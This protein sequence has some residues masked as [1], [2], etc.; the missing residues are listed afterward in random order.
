LRR[1][2]AGLIAGALLAGAA[3]AQE[4]A[5]GAAVPDSA[6]ADS[7]AADTTAAPPPPPYRPDPAAAALASFRLERSVDVETVAFGGAD[8]PAVAPGFQTLA[9]ILRLEPSV[10][11]RELSV[12]PTVETF[13][14]NG[15]GSGR[16]DLLLGSRSLIV[17]G[18]S[19]PITN[20]IMLS[21][22]GAARL[23][24][25]GASALYGPDAASGALV[26][27][28]ALPVPPELTTRAFAEEGVDGYERAGLWLAHRAGNRGSVFLTTESRRVDGF[29]P[30]TE[31]VDRQFSARVAARVGGGV[32]MTAALRQYKG[33]ARFGGFAANTVGSVVTRRTDWELG[34]FRATGEESGV[35]FEA[36]RA[37]ER[38]ETDPAPDSLGVIHAETSEI[39]G[40][41]LRLTADLPAAAGIRSVLRVE[42]SR[43]RT[44]RE[45]ADAVEELRRGA[46]ALRSTLAVGE[47]AG[48]TGTVRLDGEE[49]RRTARQGRAEAWWTA[50]PVRLF[51]VGA[52]S[53]RRAD[54]GAEGSELETHHSVQG[55]ARLALGGLEARAAGFY[56]IIEDYRREPTL[57][58]IRAR[59]PVTDAPLG[60][61]RITGADAGLATGRFRVPGVRF[62]GE[63]LLRT[64]VTLQEA[65]SRDGRERLPGRPRRIWTGE[66]FLERP[67]FQGDLLARV[68]GRLTHWGD[69]V[70]D[71]GLPVIN[72]W[73]TDVI[74]EGEIGD[75]VFFYRFHD[76]LERAD[77][78]E[79]GVRFPGFTRTYGVSWRFRG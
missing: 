59:E 44:E 47:G 73:L 68:R 51:G 77:E 12:G 11:T 19:G 27:E 61:A 41:M 64:S 54:A 34:L 9:D 79:P 69:R 17:P 4:P 15:S 74:L 30:G 45:M 33:D 40:P 26:V 46:A 3:P 48:V 37:G 50:G 58:E 1:A 42:G 63:M 72:L 5:P 38:L 22:I 35:L 36:F 28:P 25:G 76:M 75:A 78:V 55:G 67:L 31:E 53:E 16:A 52:R 49:G 21:E 2:A 6:S 66:G 24:R 65:E 23:L 8:D 39:R 7:A 70:D 56:S 13:E 10:R 43:W 32:Q 60:D 57:E 18:T 71:D 14:L 20:E 62:L 29:F